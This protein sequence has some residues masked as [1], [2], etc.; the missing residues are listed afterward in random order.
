[1]SKD[2]KQG[3]VM[4]LDL[5]NIHEISEKTGESKVWLRQQY[6]KAKDQGKVVQVVIPER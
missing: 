4:I 1:M 3:K 6:Y 5:D 2:K